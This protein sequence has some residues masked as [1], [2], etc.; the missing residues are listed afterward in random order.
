[1]TGAAGAAVTVVV[2]ACGG[3]GVSLLAAAI[4]LCR[5]RAGGP[6]WMLELDQERGDLAGAWDLPPVRTL[7]DLASVADELD[8]AQL[9]RAA[10]VH[11]SGL[12]LLLAPPAAGGAPAW[13]G[14]AAGR[15]VATAA[16]TTGEVVVDAGAGWSLT[17]DLAARPRTAVLVVCP[18]TLSAA[19]R[20]RRLVDALP[21][22]GHGRCGLVLNEGPDR[23]ELG[24]RAFRRAVGVPLA[25]ELPWRPREAAELGAGRWPRGRRAR[26]A[27]AIARLAGG[28]G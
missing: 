20:A 11:E 23:G 22:G 16:S 26:L 1:M 13:R 19:R 27:E 21:D 14:A 15:L 3:C 25:A 6:A 17:L 28:E 24:A 10:H 7:G 5:A 18:P 4:G 8:E 2:G 12:R 9:L